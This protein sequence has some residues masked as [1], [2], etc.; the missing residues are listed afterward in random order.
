MAELASLRRIIHIWLT[1]K[2]RDVQW[3]YTCKGIDLWVLEGLDH[4]V[5]ISMILD[6]IKKRLTRRLRRTSPIHTAQGR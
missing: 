2:L 6:Y 1:L 3:R 4:S 5:D